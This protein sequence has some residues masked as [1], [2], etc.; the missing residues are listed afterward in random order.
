MVAYLRPLGNFAI[1]LESRC[2]AF[3]HRMLVLGDGGVGC[4]G[5]LKMDRRES[6]VL[7]CL[8]VFENCFSLMEQLPKSAAVI[9]DGCFMYFVKVRNILMY[10]SE[11]QCILFKYNSILK[12]SAVD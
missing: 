7:N 6:Q 12:G 10:L 5:T 3:C 2:W 8:C 11:H 4:N 9:N 1:H